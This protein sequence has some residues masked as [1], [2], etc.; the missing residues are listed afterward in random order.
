[1]NPESVAKRIVSLI[2]DGRMNFPLIET[3]GY[4]IAHYV[5]GSEAEHKMT[6]FAH[7]VIENM[8]DVNK[9]IDI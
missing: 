9:R 6:T 5:A 7:S 8:E 2:S 4:W 3:V 1:M